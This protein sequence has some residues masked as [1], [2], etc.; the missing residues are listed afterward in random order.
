LI[1]VGL[2]RFQPAALA[3]ASFAT[4]LVTF[5]VPVIAVIFWPSD[6]SPGVAKVFLLNGAFAAMFAGAGLLF[7]HAAG[8]ASRSGSA[9][10]A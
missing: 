10:T 3:R 9:A 4:A 1:G 8:Q 5:L 6:F 2:S 7:R